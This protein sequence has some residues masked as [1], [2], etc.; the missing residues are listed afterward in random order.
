MEKFYTIQEV[1]SMTGIPSS[2]LRYYDKEGLLPFL[3]RSAR[4]YRLFSERDLTTLQLLEC[5]KSTGMSIREMKQYARWLEEGDASLQER[6]DMFRNRKAIV[7]EQ[8]EELRRRMDVIEHK[9]RYYKKAL[10]LGSEKT[11]LSIRLP[12]ADEFLSQKS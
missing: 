2:T 3:T 5:L 8:M 11:L 12:H 4:G 6:Y 9:C 1:S 10:E 7:R